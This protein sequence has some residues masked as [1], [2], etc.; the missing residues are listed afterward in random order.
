LRERYTQTYVPNINFTLLRLPDIG[1][2]VAT[3]GPAT[4]NRQDRNR[5]IQVNADLAPDGPGM[6]AA[7]ED[8]KKYFETNPLPPGVTYSFIGQAENF[9]ELMQNMVLAISLAILFIYLV[10]ASLYESFVTPF[11]IMLVLPLAVSGAFFGLF[12]MRKSLD[13]NSMI[14]CILLMGIA[15][16]NSVL[17]VDYA[18]QRIGEG[19][20]RRK[21]MIEA[22]RTRLRPILM[23]TV[24]LIA[25][26]LPIA[27]GLNEASRQ[28]TSMGVAIIGGLI[29]STLLSLFVIP[30]AFPIIDTAR[31]FMGRIIKKIFTPKH[32]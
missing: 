30:A 4:I 5:Y 23:T 13:L 16:K 8:I 29:S 26:M 22:G 6:N 11:T 10:L 28:R 1:K 2:L 27:I 19:M 17:L 21:A 12:L 9:K 7:I 18:T 32:S 25:G 3:E 15:T 14:G 24:A 20:E 31:L